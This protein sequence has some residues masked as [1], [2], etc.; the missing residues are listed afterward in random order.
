MDTSK[1]SN[2]FDKAVQKKRI[3]NVLCTFAFTAIETAVEIISN[4]CV[5]VIFD[6]ILKKKLLKSE[7][8][9]VEKIDKRR[10]KNA[11]LLDFSCRPFHH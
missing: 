5:A 7:E 9:G 2:C 6:D 1:F 8:K 3:L 11:D 10:M 4:H